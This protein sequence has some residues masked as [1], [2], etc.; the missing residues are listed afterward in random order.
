MVL[1]VS[2]KM[3]EFSLVGTNGCGPYSARLESSLSHR[4][5]GTSICKSCIC[6]YHYRSR[7]MK[8]P[9]VGL[10]SICAQGMHVWIASDCMI[11][12]NCHLH[13]WI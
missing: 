11:T 8:A 2:W 12:T 13:G 3:S 7:K 6:Q 1:V 9:M 10:S 5:I 4:R